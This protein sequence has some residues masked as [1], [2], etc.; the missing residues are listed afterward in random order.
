M[1]MFKKAA[2]ALLGRSRKAAAVAATT[3]VLVVTSAVAAFATPFNF[4]Y[5]NNDLLAD[6]SNDD[7]SL[8]ASVVI[9][10]SADTDDIDS[11]G[12]LYVSDWTN[13]SVAATTEVGDVYVMD[14][15]SVNPVSVPIKDSVSTKDYVVIDS[16]GKISDWSLSLFNY[17]YYPGTTS[18]GMSFEMGQTAALEIGNFPDYDRYS[19]CEHCGSWET[20]PEPSTMALFG[21][22]LLGL[23]GVARKFG[24][25]RSA[26]ALARRKSSAKPSA[27]VK[28]LG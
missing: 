22:G 5:V 4:S 19:A 7:P 10:A 1:S 23:A 25:G 16:D 17:A 2:R 15:G 14:K 21:L 9:K 28:N 18:V 27:V 13:F 24:V 20:A 3:A 6:S 8:K 26:P 11:S 12:K